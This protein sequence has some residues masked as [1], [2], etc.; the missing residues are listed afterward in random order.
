MIAVSEKK[1]SK[2]KVEFSDGAACCVVV[3]SGG[4][5]TKYESGFEITLPENKDGIFVA[6]AKLEDGRLKTSGGRAWRNMCRKH[7]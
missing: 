3:A 1:L 4:Y 6:G 7:T 5:P 2:A